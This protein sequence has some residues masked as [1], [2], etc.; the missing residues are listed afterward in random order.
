MYGR[1]VCGC[2]LFCVLYFYAFWVWFRLVVGTSR[3]VWLL[4]WCGC[5]WFL[6]FFYVWHYWP[7]TLVYAGLCLSLHC[8]VWIND[9]MHVCSL[10]SCVLGLVL[11]IFRWLLLIYLCDAFGMFYS[12][13]P[14]CVEDLLW[15]LNVSFF[16]DFLG[17]LNVSMQH[18]D[19]ENTLYRF[20]SLLWLSMVL[21]M[22]SSLRGC[23]PSTFWL[24]FIFAGFYGICNWKYC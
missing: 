11:Y 18:C 13:M 16:D 19:Y 3:S 14:C 2:F 7:A 17:H 4:F 21:L 23:F 20:C 8:T 1:Y 9:P 5:L 6:T 12:T 10:L 22:P 24:V 15:H